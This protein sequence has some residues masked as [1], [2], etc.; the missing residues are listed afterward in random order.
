M[1]ASLRLFGALF[2]SL[3]VLGTLGAPVSAHPAPRF[4]HTERDYPRRPPSALL[5]RDRER[6]ADLEWT[7]IDPPATEIWAGRSL[8]LLL[9]NAVR[10]GDVSRGPTIALDA[11]ILK[12]INLSP[13]GSQADL[14]LLK[15][16]GKLAWPLPLQE[17]AFADQRK[18]IDNNLLAAV[19]ELQY[20][21]LPSREVLKGVQADIQALSDKLEARI[22]GLTPTE[23]KVSHRFV[24]RLQETSR[25]LQDPAVATYFDRSWLSTVFT[26]G[27]LVNTMTRKGLEFAP[28]AA[29]GDDACYISLYHFLRDFDLGL[30]SCR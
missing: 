4:I 1:N 30:V 19:K 20:N 18:S 9:Q 11:A 25:T 21:K 13:V 10:S 3:T 16:A 17:D 22:H 23:Y 24:T 12:G 14:G 5:L 6:A 2:A 8:N 26:V 15:D 28:A 27:D 29:P 7:R